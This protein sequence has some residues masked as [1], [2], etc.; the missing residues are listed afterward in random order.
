MTSL[1]QCAVASI[2]SS[3]WRLLLEGFLTAERDDL[4]RVHTWGDISYNRPPDG[5]AN[6]FYFQTRLSVSVTQVTQLI[7]HGL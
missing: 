5:P 4:S 7:E 2:Y 6:P 3:G 1:V